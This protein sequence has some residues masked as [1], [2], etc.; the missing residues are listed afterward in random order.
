MQKLWWELCNKLQISK[1][2]HTSKTSLILQLSPSFA[3]IIIFYFFIVTDDKHHSIIVLND[4]AHCSAFFYLVCPSYSL[5]VYIA[6][7]HFTYEIRLV[8]WHAKWTAIVYRC[9]VGVWIEFCKCDEG[10][11]LSYK[12]RYC[13]LLAY[14]YAL[15][16]SFEP[17]FDPSGLGG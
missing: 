9:D 15:V 17:S 14:L 12:V 10:D 4:P 16:F 6:G 3:V 8:V 7:C 1:S 2:V 13:W 5:N 11:L